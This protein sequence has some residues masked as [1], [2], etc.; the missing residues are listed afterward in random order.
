[1]LRL[2]SINSR[3]FNS[4]KENLL[5]NYLLS[6][7]PAFVQETMISDPSFYS[8]LA[9]R[10]PGPCFWSPSIGRGGGSLVFVS[11]LF[12]GNVLAWR[13]DSDGRVISLLIELHGV[14]IN[15]IA[16]Y[17]P[18][19]LTDRKAFFDSL[20]E[21]F[22]PA[23]GV[24]VVGD[25]NCY[26][27]DLDKFGRNFS[28]ANYLSDFRSTFNFVDAFRKLHPRSRE[29]S[30]FNSDFSIGSRLDKF[31]VSRPFASFISVCNI[32]PCCFSDHD[33]V[34]LTLVLNTNFARGP[35]LWKFNNSLLQDSQL[36][37][38]ISE[39]ISDLSG[40][41][42]LFPSVKEWWDFFKR[43]L[44]SE[45]V[46][47]TSS[48]R[49]SLC[50]ERVVL[51]NS[52]I[53]CKRRLVQGDN[54]VVAEIASLES[55]LKALTLRD[56]EGV[57]VRSRAKWLEEGEKPTRY[58]FRLERERVERSTVTSILNLDEVEV[59]TRAEIEQA[60]VQFY[61]NLFSPEPIDPDCK[62]LLLS[63]FSRSLS[64]FD[65]DLCNADF[66]LQE[67]TDS[68]NSLSLGK[69]PG[70]DGFSVEFY[71]KIWRLLGPLLLRV[72]LEC[73]RDGFL[74]A[75]MRG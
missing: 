73:I 66:S 28:P 7:S 17:A 61:S 64:D 42:D 31:F 21:F 34:N 38:F 20:H 54:S 57:K 19:S 58:F 8:S 59:F 44:Q 41:I 43:C 50:R 26:E 53:D 1:M 56:L 48:K 52:L 68:L 36:C 18:T 10:L 51:T 60:H 47:F 27:R 71:S 46:S 29:V 9:S 25:F 23:D 63:C 65:R 2:I 33:Y 5:F 14:K 24:I 12:E 32:L 69:A 72:A 11:S 74:C 75:T 39:R 16:I 30:W 35:G 55:R 3:G 13:K 49:K 70:P 67:L 37:S 22:L 4:R 15:L 40:C 62:Q 6:A 45:I